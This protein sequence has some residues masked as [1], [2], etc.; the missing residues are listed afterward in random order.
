MRQNIF[1]LQEKPKDLNMSDIVSLM[2]QSMFHMIHGKIYIMFSQYYLDSDHK[3]RNYN[4]TY[5][6]CILNSHH[7]LN[8]C[9]W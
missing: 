2:D 9:Y 5:L 1:H 4:Y 8:I 3:I 6:L 7:I